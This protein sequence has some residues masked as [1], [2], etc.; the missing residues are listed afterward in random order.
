MDDDMYH[1]QAAP[2]YAL[3]SDEHD[4]DDEAA[5]TTA[6][7]APASKPDPVVEFRGA[8]VLQPTR[9]VFLVGEVAE[10]FAKGA[11]TGDASATVFVDGEQAA[12]THVISPS[13]TVVFTSIALPLVSLYPFAHA[14]LSKLSPT[15]TTIVAPYHSPSYIAEQP[16]AS[17]LIRYLSSPTPNSLLTLEQAGHLSPFSPPNLLHGL[18]PLLLTLSTLS[19]IEASLI[20]LPSIASPT[21]LNGPFL[22]PS[23]WSNTIYDAGGPTSLSD[24]RGVYADVQGSLKAVGKGLG[25]DEWYDA[26]K[27]DGKSSDWIERSRR[28]KRREQAGSMY[29]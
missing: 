25:W 6:P 5:E 18:A 8:T 13:V 20:L 9:V 1:S 7:K 3:E 26:K 24:S 12:S 4:S 27:R 17:P 14:L 19:E 28:E 11:K 23:S 21:S 2:A 22:G 15:S 16:P 29:M 10:V